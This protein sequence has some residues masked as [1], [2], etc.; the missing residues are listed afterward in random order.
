MTERLYLNLH[1]SQH[2]SMCHVWSFFV[3][4]VDA[5]FNLDECKAHGSSVWLVLYTPHS[6]G[7]KVE[8]L[9]RG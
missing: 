5:D 3:G 9:R 4:A 1:F 2:G 8:K 7:Q 6:K